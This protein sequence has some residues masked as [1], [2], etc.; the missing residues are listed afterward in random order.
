ME[1]FYQNIE[2]WASE[3]DQGNLLSTV[4]DLINSKGKIKIAEIGVYKGRGTALWN[5]ELINKKI[6][7]QYYAIDHFLGSL[8]HEKGVDY[9][10]E[11]CSNLNS[12]IDKIH[13]IKN[14]SLTESTNYADHFF[15]IVYID[16]SHDYQSVM[17]DIQAWLP[18]VKPEGVIC[19]DDYI[20]GWPGVVQAVNDSFINHSIS[21]IGNQQW[22]VKL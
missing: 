13:I 9:Y 22:Y 21:K 6:D 8:E 5:V 12:I 2:G 1:H 19:G 15:D 16:A 4:L 3:Y 18:K 20:D 17:N 7:Y 10:S 14:D 11:A